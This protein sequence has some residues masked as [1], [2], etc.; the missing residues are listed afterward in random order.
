[1]RDGNTHADSGK[2]NKE[3]NVGG[4]MFE[5]YRK[6][7]DSVDGEAVEVVGQEKEMMNDIN[8]FHYKLNSTCCPFQYQQQYTSSH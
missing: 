8:E 6:A 4:L 5:N 7:M 1:M 3:W 2:V